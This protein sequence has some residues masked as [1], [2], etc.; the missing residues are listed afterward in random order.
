MIR[1]TCLMIALSVAMVAPVS[2]KAEEFGAF[3][4]YWVFVGA[5]K[6]DGGVA[7]RAIQKSARRCGLEAYGDWS[8]KFQVPPGKLIY[9]LDKYFPVNVYGKNGRKKAEALRA[10]VSKCIPD[11]YVKKV[12]YAGE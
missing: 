9:T 6:D 1:K 7:G 10:K 11:A 4:A 12:W 3:E 5:T 2:V 8:W